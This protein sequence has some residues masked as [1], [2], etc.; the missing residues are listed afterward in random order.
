[1]MEHQID[2]LFAHF[3]PATPASNWGEHMAELG[4]ARADHDAIEWINGSELEGTDT[5]PVPDED[6]EWVPDVDGASLEDQIREFVRKDN[7]PM[8]GSMGNSDSAVNGVCSLVQRV[9][10]TSLGEIDNMIAE[11]Q[12]LRMFL[13]SEGE[14]LQRELA[15][16]DKLI[17][18]TLRS[19]RIIANSLPSCKLIAD[20]SD[21]A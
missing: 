11:L 20:N 13:V 14:R 19:S 4:I 17:R 6:A 7:R 18:E 16:Y 15:D 1:M 9:A 3:L 21:T 8:H 10:G 12:R 2:N 5:N